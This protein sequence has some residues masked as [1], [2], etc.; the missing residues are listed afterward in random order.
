MSHSLL[1]SKP[2]GT[3]ALKF[4]T[5]L[6]PNPWAVLA[7]A[8]SAPGTIDTVWFRDVYIGGCGVTSLSARTRAEGN[9]AE[10]VCKMNF[11]VGHLGLLHLTLHECQAG[12]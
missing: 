3:N 9:E 11:K 2:A 8:G 4:T 5:M 12:K 1:R 7:T 10:D 6:N